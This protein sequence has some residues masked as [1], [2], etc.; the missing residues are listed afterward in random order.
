MELCQS[1]G[2]ILD[3]APTL[4]GAL[5]H[6]LEAKEALLTRFF[7]VFTLRRVT[8]SVYLMATFVTTNFFIVVMRLFIF[9]GGVKSTS[10]FT[11]L[12]GTWQ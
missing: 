3:L 8:F 10:G 5:A 9:G 12:H 4:L 1:L 11:V 2:V 6:T 7:Y